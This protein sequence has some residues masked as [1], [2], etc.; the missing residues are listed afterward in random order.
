[1]ADNLT[2]IT[3]ELVSIITQIKRLN[4]VRQKMDTEI[5]KINEHVLGKELTQIVKKKALVGTILSLIP[6]IGTIIYVIILWTMYL[7]INKKIGLKS[8]S[9]IKATVINGMLT[10]IIIYLIVVIIML[11]ILSAV[12]EVVILPIGIIISCAV[13]YYLTIISAIIYFK[14][15]TTNLKKIYKISNDSMVEMDKT[16]TNL[17]KEEKDLQSNLSIKNTKIV[18]KNVSDTSTE[19]CPKCNSKLDEKSKYCTNCGEQ[20]IRNKVCPN[21]NKEIKQNHKFCPNCGFTLNE[22]GRK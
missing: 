20:I 11:P 1:M 18:N 8:L 4:V 15:L 19:I 14:L 7:A 21:C 10:N 16:D 2:D 9:N 3:F 13:C 12:V 6:F 5:D 17:Y 22:L